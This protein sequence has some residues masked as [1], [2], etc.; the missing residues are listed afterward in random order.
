MCVLGVEGSEKKCGPPPRIISGTALTDS[1]WAWPWTLLPW[2]HSC[3]G[4]TLA[5]GT[6]LPWAHSCP[7][8][9][10]NGH[11]LGMDTHA[12]GTLLSR[13]H[14]CPGHT[15][16]MGTLLPWIHSCPGHTL[17]LDTLLQWTHS[18]LGHTLAMDTLL[19]WTH[20]CDGHTLASASSSWAANLNTPTSVIT[21]Q[22]LAKL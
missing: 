19:P 13:A 6:P 18:Y 21:R 20:S 16:V 1:H 15:L 22:K 14:S 5:L 2:A 12:L 8:H 7:G 11:T 10:W 4:H 9:S 17:A 3:F